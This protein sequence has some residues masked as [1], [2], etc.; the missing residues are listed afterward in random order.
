MEERNKN[1]IQ[2]KMDA[3]FD[4]SIN[5]SSYR[6]EQIKDRLNMRKQKVFNLLFS[7]RKDYLQTPVNGRNEID[8]NSL[9]CAE[10]IKKNVN[11]YLK[12]GYDI[13]QWFKYIFSSNKNHIYVALYLLRRYIE[14]QLLEL[15]AK[16]RMLSRNDTELIQKLVDYLLITK[17]INKSGI[18]KEFNI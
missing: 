2:E 7:K 18:H 3:Y 15:D 10:D 4:E 16:K 11:E 14:L 6:Q 5:S 12:S 13:K 1:K 9:D 8:I 17:K